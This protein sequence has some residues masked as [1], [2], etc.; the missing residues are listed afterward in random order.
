MFTYITDAVKKKARRRFIMLMLSGYFLPDRMQRF[1]DFTYFVVT[2]EMAMNYPGGTNVWSIICVNVLNK[3][4][5]LAA[6]QIKYDT[7]MYVYYFCR[8]RILRLLSL[9]NDMQGTMRYV[10]R[11]ERWKIKFCFLLLYLLCC[12]LSFIHYRA[13]TI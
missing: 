10:L 8:R 11:K 12:I 9:Q 2:N 6:Y 1:D 5:L 4:A 3:I 13:L 7:V